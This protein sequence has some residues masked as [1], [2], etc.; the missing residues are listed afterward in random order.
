[1]SI[2]GLQIENPYRPPR[3]CPQ[4]GDRIEALRAVDRMQWILQHAGPTD[5]TFEGGFFEYNQDLRA[6]PYPITMTHRTYEWQQMAREQMGVNRAYI[7]AQQA[8]ISAGSA[9]YYEAGSD[10]MHPINIGNAIPDL[11]IDDTTQEI[12][13]RHV[14]DEIVQQRPGNPTNEMAGNIASGG[15]KNRATLHRHGVKLVDGKITSIM[16][17]NGR[18]TVQSRPSENG[19]TLQ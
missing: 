14:W 18:D 9:V 11:I 17:R 10:R 6:H 3:R 2:A 5:C 4:C 19:P 16:D 7:N 1:M 8:A 12:N 15:N 13:V